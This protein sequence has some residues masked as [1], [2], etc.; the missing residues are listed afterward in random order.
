MARWTPITLV[1]AV[2]FGYLRVRKSAILRTS[3]ALRIARSV[4]QEFA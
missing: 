1:A 4:A 2:L 3:T